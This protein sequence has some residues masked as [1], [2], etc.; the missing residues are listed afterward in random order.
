MDAGIERKSA[1][2]LVSLRAEA[3]ARARMPRAAQAALHAA[4]SNGNTT[5]GDDDNEELRETEQ[6]K[7][8]HDR[9]ARFLASPGSDAMRGE[10]KGVAEA[11]AQDDEMCGPWM[12][13]GVSAGTSAAS[14]P[15]AASSPLLVPPAHWTQQAHSRFTH[16]HHF[17]RE[18]VCRCSS[19]AAHHA[20]RLNHIGPLMPLS[21]SSAPMHECTNAPM[22]EYTNTRMPNAPY[23]CGWRRSASRGYESR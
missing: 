13:A 17:L 15:D 21:P 14:A 8:L 11:R 19:R 10:V 1:D 16:T 22:R 4:H 6:S 3:P 20:Y 7:L 2:L 9:L 12:C 23:S 5:D 18:Q